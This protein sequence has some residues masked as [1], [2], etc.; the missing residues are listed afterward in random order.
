M[1]LKRQ[2]NERD[3]LT[4]RYSNDGSIAHLITATVGMAEFLSI[5]P[6]ILE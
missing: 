2:S 6:N 4:I 1:Q 5:L 3:I